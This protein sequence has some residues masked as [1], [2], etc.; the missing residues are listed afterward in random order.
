MKKRNKTSKPAAD[1]ST[2]EIVQMIAR[3]IASLPAREQRAAMD[4]FD[5][6]ADAI[7]RRGK[8]APK[9]RKSPAPRSRRSRS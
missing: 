1:E 2:E 5:R 7:S 8:K 6:T 3:S 9:P 4:A